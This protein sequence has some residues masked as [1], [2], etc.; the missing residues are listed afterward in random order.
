MWC[1][2]VNTVGGK[3]RIKQCARQRDLKRML[4]YSSVEN[5]GPSVLEYPYYDW[6]V[7]PIPYACGMRH[8][9]VRCFMF[10]HSLFKGL[11]FLSA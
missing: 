9:R 6:P 7:L 8:G 5:I 11:L 1:G 3:R 10:N 4:A 2:P